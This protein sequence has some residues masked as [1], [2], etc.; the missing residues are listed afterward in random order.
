MKKII[1]ILGILLLIFNSCNV[2]NDDERNVSYNVEF[3]DTPQNFDYSTTIIYTGEDGFSKSDELQ[4]A[5]SL[6]SQ[7]GGSFS[8]GDRV[9]ISANTA[10][11]RGT[12]TLTI[13]C[14]DCK[15]E[16]LIDDRIKK[17]IN[18]ETIKVGE[19]SLNLE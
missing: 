11:T 14:K 3:K 12:I 9:S 1:F 18:L 4:S 15:N 13:I 7:G 19:L 6:W 17:I 2:S 8:K 5:F 16:N 10:L